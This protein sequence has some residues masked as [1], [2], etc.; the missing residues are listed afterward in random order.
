LTARRLENLRLIE[1]EIL[2]LYPKIHVTCKLM[3]V[4]SFDSVAAA[5]TDCA[6][7]VDI[8]INNAGIVVSS[9]HC[10]LQTLYTE[11]I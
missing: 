1:S 10:H 7:T 2:A 11:N 4:S 6:S 9:T 5:L 8:L 3:D